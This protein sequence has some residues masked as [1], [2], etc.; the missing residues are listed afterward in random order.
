MTEWGLYTLAEFIIALFELAT[1]LVPFLV[2]YFILRFCA[3]RSGHTVTGLL[4]GLVFAAYLFAVLY[5][6]GIG[7]VYELGRALDGSDPIFN[8]NE[9]NFIPFS[10]GVSLGTALNVVLFVPLGFLLPAIWRRGARLAPV[11]GFGFLLSLSIELLQLLNFRT[12][13]VDDLLMN[14][15]GTIVGY[16]VFKLWERITSDKE[17]VAQHAAYP[18]N[19]YRGR[20]ALLPGLAE[21]AVYVAAMLVGHFF[22]FDG[23]GIAMMAYGMLLG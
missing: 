1:L 8:H 3:Q 19:L 13:D 16:G 21:P 22:L 5:V 7:T 17:Q 9:I 10:S 4:P 11:A 15:L 6:T 18:G 12:T 2:T 14:T 20:H 23:Y